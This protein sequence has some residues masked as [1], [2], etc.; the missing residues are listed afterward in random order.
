MRISRTLGGWALGVALAIST[1]AGAS[2]VTVTPGNSQGWASTGNSGGGSSSIT[3]TSLGGAFADGAVQLNGDRT[4]FEV[5]NTTTGFGL[6]SN[7]TT[8][9]YQWAVESTGAGVATAQ[10]PA[11]RALVFAPG[12]GRSL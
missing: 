9:N 1:G 6:L 2:V 12:T 10:A 4:R 7:L 8:Y 3:A 11:L 5:Q